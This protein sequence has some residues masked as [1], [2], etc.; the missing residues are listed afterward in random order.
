MVLEYLE[1]GQ[2]DYT[3]LNSQIKIAIAN[4]KSTPINFAR[5]NPEMTSTT[6]QPPN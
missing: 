5:S 2:G 4:F 3:Y 6:I 1:D